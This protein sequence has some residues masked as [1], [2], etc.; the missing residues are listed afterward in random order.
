MTCSVSDKANTAAAPTLKIVPSI[1]G[2][3]MLNST[4]VGLKTKHSDEFT[5]VSNREFINVALTHEE[6][7]N[8]LCVE[9]MVHFLETPYTDRARRWVD[10]TR[11]ILDMVI[12]AEAINRLMDIPADKRGVTA[13][14]KEWRL[15]VRMIAVR[16][17]DEY[18]FIPMA[19]S[20]A[21][22]VNNACSYLFCVEGNH[23]DPMTVIKP[24]G[25][26]PN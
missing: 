8:H 17:E 6:L 5:L 26:R 3:M 2:T 23:G 7:A 24:A 19:R 20:G 10:T 14:A 25:W 18:R 11:Y 12:T 21:D 15:R 9:D 13:L 16:H 22:M 1:W 4:L